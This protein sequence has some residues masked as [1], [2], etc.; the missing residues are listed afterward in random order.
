MAEK[1]Q[2]KDHV[3]I[4]GYGI[5]G[6]RIGEILL[7]SKMKFVV[8]E[9]D[10]TKVELL[11]E[12]GVGVIVG[13]ATS[14]KTLKEANIASARAI[15]VVMDDDAKNLFTVITA[16]SLNPKIIIATRANNEFI[17]NKLEGAGASF[18]AT[19]NISTSEELFKEIIKEL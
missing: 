17:K 7:Q 12:R 18:I 16:K 6:E 3:V 4:C 9:Q 10:A 8:I 1:L 13:D 2:F 5:V 11:E 14:S 19:P 15:A